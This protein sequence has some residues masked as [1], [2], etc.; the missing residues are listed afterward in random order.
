MTIPEYLE[1]EL[2][3]IY[4]IEKSKVKMSDFGIPQSRIRSIYLFSRKDLNKLGLF[5]RKIIKS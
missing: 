3:D 2:K 4:S 5:P 1:F